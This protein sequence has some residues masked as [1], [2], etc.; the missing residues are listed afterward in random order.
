MHEAL[1]V[2][3]DGG[4]ATFTIKRPRVNA[5]SLDLLESFAEE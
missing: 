3:R 4:I 2:E 1:T 5:L